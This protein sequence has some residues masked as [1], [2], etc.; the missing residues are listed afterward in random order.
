MVATFGDMLEADFFHRM[1][2]LSGLGEIKLFNCLME[3]LKSQSPKFEVESYHGSSKQVSFKPFVPW[4]RRERARCE[5]ADL[6][7]VWF[8]DNPADNVRITFLQA[9]YERKKVIKPSMH[10]YSANLEQWDLLANRPEIDGVGFS[11]P[12]DLLSGATLPSIGSFGFFYHSKAKIELYYSSADCLGIPLPHGNGR[13]YKLKARSNIRSMRTSQAGI[14]E[15]VHAD[16]LHD[17]GDSLYAGLIGSPINECSANWLTSVLHGLPNRGTLA[18]ELI[19]HLLKEKPRE[20]F[21]RDFLNTGTKSVVLI[22]GS[23]CHVEKNRE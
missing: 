14:A 5:L 16:N 18:S 10:A 7:I 2:N 17:F 23:P 8:P 12:P 6:L 9:K 15:C 3:S 19:G 20:P 22:K 1:A 13:Y 11:V 21:K 4:D